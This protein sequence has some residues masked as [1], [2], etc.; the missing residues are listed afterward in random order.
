MRAMGDWDRAFNRPRRVRSGVAVAVL[1]G[2]V[3]CTLVVL[4]GAGLMLRAPG[5]TLGQIGEALISGGVIGAVIFAVE[6]V[7]DARRELAADRRSF[8]LFLA[9]TRNLNGAD[10]SGADLRGLDLRGRDLRNANL[11]FARLDGADLSFAQMAGARIRYAELR[12]TNLD[13]A[14]LRLTDLRHSDFSRASLAHADLRGALLGGSRLV[15]ANCSFADFSSLTDDEVETIRSEGSVLPVKWYFTG[16]TSRFDEVD[17]RNCDLRGANFTDATLDGTDFTFA[18][19]SD[20]S[21]ELH[22]KSYERRWW[23]LRYAALGHGDAVMEWSSSTLADRHEN[24]TAIMAGAS[25]REARIEA[26]AA[27]D[28][29]LSSEQMSQC[30]IVSHIAQVPLRP[31][32]S[33]R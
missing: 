32:R 17:A 24:P 33:P 10:L 21:S 12:K 4:A 29:G 16:G 26:L 22:E 13:Q 11:N 7:R 25:L 15:V 9:T 8:L 23:V 6:S 28:V 5:T 14:D 18:R 3:G 1:V 20:S 2:L 19:L 31:Q 27:A 30:R